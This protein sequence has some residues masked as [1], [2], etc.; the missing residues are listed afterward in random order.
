MMKNYRFIYIYIYSKWTWSSVLGAEREDEKILEMRMTR[1]EKIRE[2]IVRD[3][4]DIKYQNNN[5][6]NIEF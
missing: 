1:T 5:K 3:V 2:M 4:E 6:N